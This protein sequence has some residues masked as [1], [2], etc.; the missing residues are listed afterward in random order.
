MPWESGIVV[1]IKGDYKDVIHGPCLLCIVLVCFYES[2][3]SLCLGG[4]RSLSRS[5]ETIATFPIALACR[6]FSVFSL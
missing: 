2:A 6:V 3:T 5:N 4:A 1:S